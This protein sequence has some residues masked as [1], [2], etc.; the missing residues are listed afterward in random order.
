M[1]SNPIEADKKATATD[2]INID[3]VNEMITFTGNCEFCN[4]PIKPFP[5]LHQQ[6]NIPYTTPYATATGPAHTPEKGI[7]ARKGTCY[8]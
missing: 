5:T 1:T 3:T 8:F 2:Q 6:V 4:N 7:R